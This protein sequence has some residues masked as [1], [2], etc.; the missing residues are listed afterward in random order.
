VFRKSGVVHSFKLVDPSLFVFGS[1]AAVSYILI[2]KATKF[3]FGRND[4]NC[5][6]KLYISIAPS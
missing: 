3:R 6:S 5:Q 2:L 1:H 4:S